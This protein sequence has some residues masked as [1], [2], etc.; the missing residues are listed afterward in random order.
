MAWLGGEGARKVGGIMT[1][2]LLCRGVRWPSPETSIAGHKREYGL[3]LQHTKRLQFMYV[4]MLSSKGPAAA[5][6]IDSITH[7]QQ[8]ERVSS[9][10]VS[11]QKPPP[12]G[13]DAIRY[14]RGTLSTNKK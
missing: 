9:S 5:D 4:H 2:K 14:T 10:T 12:Q 1:A 3:S 8:I 6:D 7:S 11:D 13:H